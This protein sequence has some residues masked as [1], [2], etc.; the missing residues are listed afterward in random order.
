MHDP[1]RN[2][3]NI[4]ECRRHF[5]TVLD[6]ACPCCARAVMEARLNRHGELILSDEANSEPNALAN[7]RR[8]LAGVFFDP[9]EVDQA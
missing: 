1:I 7:A 6:E 4:S 9:A 3:D 8:A 5:Q 2:A